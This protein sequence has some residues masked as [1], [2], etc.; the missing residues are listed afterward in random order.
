MEKESLDHVVKLQQRARLYRRTAAFQLQLQSVMERTP[1]AEPENQGGEVADME[2]VHLASA[3]DLQQGPAEDSMAVWR[4]RH[5]Q[6]MN[7]LVREE[8]DQQRRIEQL[9]ELTDKLREETER[10]IEAEKKVTHFIEILDSLGRGTRVEQLEL[11]VASL[12]VKNHVLEENAGKHEEQI[13]AIVEEK[14]ELKRRYGELLTDNERLHEENAS[15]KQKC[16]NQ[17]KQLEK[18]HLERLEEGLKTMLE[19]QGIEYEEWMQETATG[20]SR[21]KEAAEGSS[22]LSKEAAEGGSVLSKEATEGSSVLSSEEA[23]KTTDQDCRVIRI[24]LPGPVDPTLHTG[25]HLQ[26][27]T[28]EQHRMEDEESLQ[29]TAVGSSR[30]ED[31]PQLADY[32]FCRVSLRAPDVAPVLEAAEES[33]VLSSEEGTEIADE[34]LG[35]IKT[36]SERVIELTEYRASLS[37]YLKLRTNAIAPNL[38][39]MVGELVGARLIS[40]AGSLMSLAKHPSSKV[41]I[42][43]A[44]KALFRLTKKSTPKFCPGFEG[45]ADPRAGCCTA[46]QS[47]MLRAR[48]MRRGSAA[49]EP[50]QGSRTSPTS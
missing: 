43:G 14:N 21:E 20:S 25:V 8:C 26:G 27:K 32:T 34:D 22:V 47:S 50:C 4:S 28:A 49:R 3:D 17:Y 35:N 13:R 48:T 30:E 39:Y 16:D 40:Q 33:S 11:K 41:Q 18:L 38:T 2:A 46:F 36:L 31:C 19:L 9:R 7:I 10:R 37:E 5:R 15:L 44:E 24:H 29:E 12:S 23:P 1:P 45:G 6:C 42:R